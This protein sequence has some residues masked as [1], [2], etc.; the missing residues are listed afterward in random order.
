M[1]PE[2]DRPK[3]RYGAQGLTASLLPQTL[4]A[5]TY[6][7]PR[8]RDQ[9][10]VRAGGGDRIL[11]LSRSRGLQFHLDGRHKNPDVSR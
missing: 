2:Q 11:F 6:F 10:L 3:D 7:P 4:A 5:R 9:M 8:C 1:D